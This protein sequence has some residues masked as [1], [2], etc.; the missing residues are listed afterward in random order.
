MISVN[1]WNIKKRML[2][3]YNEEQQQDLFNN[4]KTEEMKSYQNKFKFI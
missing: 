3:C 2:V 1:I 4:K